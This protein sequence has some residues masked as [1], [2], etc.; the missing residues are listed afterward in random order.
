M[1]GRILPSFQPSIL[2]F[3]T[4]MNLIRDFQEIEAG[5]LE[6]VG[7]KGLSLGQLARA[8]LPVPPGF[9][10][11]TDAYRAGANGVGLP[12]P[13]AAQVLDA[14]RRLGAGLVAVRSSATSEDGQADSFAGQQETI[15]GVQGEEDLLTAL[16]RCWASLHTDRARAYRQKRDIADA[17]LAMAVVVQRLVAA[18][19]S[20]VLFTRDP[21]DAEGKRMMIEAAW[22]LGES[23]V[24][25][26]VTPDRYHIDRESGR[27]VR[28]EIA[29]KPTMVGVT[30]PLP[31]PSDQQSRP[32]LQDEQL[33]QLAEF[34]RRIEAFYG[35]ARDVEWAWADGQFW[36]LQARP[37][38]TAG[39]FER[40]Q[41]RREEIATLVAKAE[42]GGTVWARY[43]LAEVLPAPTP[44]TWSIVRRF[45]SGRGGLG[46]MYRDLGFD[47]DPIIDEEGFIDLICGRPYVN[48][49]RE[50][51]LFF[52][53]FPYGHSFAT[54]KANPERALY[55]QPIVLPERTSG[56]FWLRLPVIF[57]KMLRAHSRMKR[58]SASF[59]ELLRNETFPRFAH[60]V[61]AEHQVDVRRRSPQ[62]LLD[63][64]NHWIRLTLD[65]FARRSL[66]PSVFAGL[67]VAN[68]ERGLARH[69]PADEAAKQARALL[70]GVR[71]DPEADLP[72]ALQQLTQGQVTR[73][74]FLERFGHRGPKEMELA[75]PRWADE[76]ELLPR[77][78]TR[79]NPDPGA[80]STGILANS[81]TIA[82]LPGKL[83]RA[84]EPELEKARTYFGLRE[85][86]KHYLMM[87]Y[88]LIRR[89]LVELDRR[90]QLGGG[91]FYLLPEELPR[92]VAGE[93]FREVIAER[94]RRRTLALSLE[95]PP[96]LFSDDL[97]AIGRP[98]AVAGGKE[99]KGTPLS[100]GVA[101]GP[102]LV[103]QEP[104]D[105]AQAPEEYVLVCPSTDPAWVPLF[106]RAKALVMETGGVLSHGAIVAREFGLPA[107]AGIPAVH[108]RIEPG[109]FLHVDGNTGQVV[110]PE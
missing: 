108:Q 14:Y 75:E 13:L 32:C 6:A 8:G 26:R 70:G 49:S 44:M 48:L 37:I 10:V 7:G 38:T 60:E 55:P 9:C 66:R 83:Q 86:A 47:P 21:L 11:T 50:P 16:N 78:G 89:I 29:V 4:H 40:E 71:A 93:D 25:G 105:P 67:A 17:D 54:L 30:G 79:Q 98:M 31:V 76:P 91:I 87:G 100:A 68:L 15:L 20:G 109:Q 95:A 101:E 41:V 52:R 59:N 42:P 85:T 90:H 33:K 34:G 27:L 81:A 12:E 102:A 1:E 82:E 61:E 106:L 80:P 45:M 57:Y 39:A 62:E 88:A 63:T 5:D 104:I 43:N 72:A 99:M 58:E 36:V 96:V 77:S 56:R 92:L 35:D 84:L 19:A 51:Q 110:L 53:D 23:V 28:Q 64:L 97:E 2:P 65:D 24:S 3:P 94:R 18:E 74:W 73:V 46:L 103:L 107:V 22:G 69:L